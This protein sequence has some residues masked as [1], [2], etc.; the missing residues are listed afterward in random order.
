MADATAKMAEVYPDTKLAIV[1]HAPEPSIPNVA[2]IVFDV[3]EAA[4]LGG[5]LAAA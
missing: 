4:F 5:Y 2:G 3:D 1:D